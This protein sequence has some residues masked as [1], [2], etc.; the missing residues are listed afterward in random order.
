MTVDGGAP[1]V[2][3]GRFELPD[4]G[5]GPLVLQFEAEE[6]APTWLATSLI[7]G[8]NAARVHLAEVDEVVAFQSLSGVTVLGVDLPAGA[9]DGIGAVTAEV[10]IYDDDELVGLPSTDVVMPIHGAAQ[11]RLFDVSG[12]PETLSATGTMTLDLDVID[13]LGDLVQG[14][15][16]D[17]WRFNE[18]TGGWTA[19]GSGAVYA[20]SDGS[21]GWLWTGTETGLVIASPGPGAVGCIS[22]EVSDPT[23]ASVAGAHVAVVGPNLTAAARTDGDGAFQVAAP[24]GVS[25]DLS[26]VGVVEGELAASVVGA[27]TATAET[28]CADAGDVL[29]RS[30][31]CVSG[32]TLTAGGSPQEGV[33]VTASSGAT[34]V[35][36]GGGSYCLE[37]PVLTSVTMHGP[38]SLTGTDGY[39]PW[40]VV[41]QAGDPACA[42]GCP[43]IAPV[44]PYPVTHCAQGSLEVDGSPF[45]GSVLV[46][47]ERSMAVPVYEVTTLASGLF[48]SEVGTGTTVSV[49]SADPGHDCAPGTVDTFGWNGSSCG[50]GGCLGVGVVECTTAR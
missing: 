5:T 10:T 14:Q 15:T 39:L 19:A 29:V 50:G 27:M 2:D 38:T 9:V 30:V 36:G 8:D 6:H 42:G 7:D 13:P 45:E 17:A 44:R 25:V 40:T 48:C 49:T 32:Q 35:S 12:A 41:T 47:D 22:G 33:T 23:G 16:L 31:T 34:A 21:L 1:T 11:V 46:Y 3:D 26:A 43:N 28:P 4:V 37:V 20:N 18:A 24:I